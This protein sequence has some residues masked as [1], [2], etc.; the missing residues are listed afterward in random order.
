MVFVYWNSKTYI[1]KK[2]NSELFE[3]LIKYVQIVVVDE[4]HRA[5]AYE[6]K[7]AI[8]MLMSYSGKKKALIGLTATPGRTGDIENELFR[9]MFDNKI[10]DIDISILNQLNLSKQRQ[11]I[12]SLRVM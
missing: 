2:N 3:K 7:K 8:N 9:G 1:N 10:I 5:G 4:A 11:I 6:T 12:R